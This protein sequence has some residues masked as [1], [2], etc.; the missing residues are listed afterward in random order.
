MIESVCCAPNDFTEDTLYFRDFRWIIGGW[1]QELGRNNWCQVS[2]AD[3]IGH[4][5]T[6][7]AGTGT[8]RDVKSLRTF[9]FDRE[10]RFEDRRI[11]SINEQLGNLAVTVTIQ[12]H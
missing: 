1:W 7:R 12:I 2:I 3:T 9:S 8:I 6:T 11:T 5:Y 4:E 10:S